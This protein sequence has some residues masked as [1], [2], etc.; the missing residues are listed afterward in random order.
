MEIKTGKIEEIK[1]ILIGNEEFLAKETQI[2]EENLRKLTGE[3]EE[4]D[5]LK[6]KIRLL[7]RE[8]R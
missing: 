3:I 1:K 2:Y 6:K 8:K 5:D 4:I 7:M